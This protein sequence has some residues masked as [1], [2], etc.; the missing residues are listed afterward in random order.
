MAARTATGSAIYAIDAVTATVSLIATMQQ[1]AGSDYALWGL[2]SHDGTLYAT[3]SGT[4][5]LFTVDLAARSATQLGGDD[6]GAINETA[7]RGIASHDGALYMVGAATDKLYQINTTT[8]AATAVGSATAFGSVAETEP[9][10]L[11]S[12]GDALYMTGATNDWLYTVSTIHG[13]AARLGAQDRFGVSEEAPRGLASGYQKPADISIEGGGVVKYAGAPAAAGDAYTVYAQV[14]DGQDAHGSSSDAIDDHARIQVVVEN[15]APSMDEQSY[16]FA[17][18]PGSDG[19]TVPVAVGLVSGTDPDPGDSV[20]YSLRAQQMFALNQTTGTANDALFRVDH[21]TGAVERVSDTVNYG[22]GA[23]S[24]LVA[25]GLT[26]HDDKLYFV[27]NQTARLYTVDPFTGVATQVGTQNGF[28]ISENEPTALASHNGVLYMIGRSNH[29]LYTV[30]ATTGTATAVNSSTVNFGLSGTPI[31]SG[32]VSHGGKLYMLNSTDDRLETVSATTGAAQQV[33]AS[34]QFGVSEGSALALA[35]TGDTLYMSGL[36]T[37]KL[38]SLNT[39]TGAAT[40][41]ATLG[42][43]LASTQGLTVAY[44]R[45]RDYRI[46]ANTGAISYTGAAAV[47]GTHAFNAHVSDGKASDGTTDSALDGGA[48]VTVEFRNRKPSFDAESYRFDLAT[49]TD[50]SSSAVSLGDVRAFDPDHDDTVSYAPLPSDASTVIYAVQDESGYASDGLFTINSSTAAVA[51][52]GTAVNFGLGESD[53]GPSSLT[54]H[55]GLMYMTGSTDGNLYTVS[56]FDGRATRIGNATNFGVNETSPS[57][58]ASH[59]GT[60]YMIGQAT[61]KLYTVDP[62]KRRRCCRGRDNGQLR[63]RECA[64]PYRPD[65]T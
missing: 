9:S 11:A 49:G 50:G 2:A 15:S 56:S 6:F 1:L 59:N 51:R 38:Y 22:F 13:T 5:R 14:H 37:R 19:S 34:T 30:D 24:E 46:N 29:R 8:G 21:S 61:H 20:S 62:I 60:L 48:A 31:R 36:A 16:E 41:V 40:S 58:L 45:P 64:E 25:S 27:G 53:I 32:L 65:V 43:A 55:N 23:S 28:G 52:V 57:G 63:R 47:A 18:S 17:L 12:H 39:S 54:W 26:W 42:T 33:G 3:T 10:G 44:T 35:S 4:G 7:P